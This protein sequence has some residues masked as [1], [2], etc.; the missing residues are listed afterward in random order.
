[1][2]LKKV[3]RREKPL[4]HPV[5]EIRLSSCAARS[6]VTILTELSWL[7]LALRQLQNVCLLTVSNSAAH[8]PSRETDSLSASEAIPCILWNPKVHYRIY[9][10]QPLNHILCQINP[11][12]RPPNPVSRTKVHISTP[13]RHKGGAKVQPHSFFTSALDRGEWPVSRPDRLTPGEKNS[14]PVA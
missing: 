4:P 8:S 13:R 5:I 3:W 12:Q 14:L 6:V 1:V 10:R 7:L 2:G 9:K 11:V